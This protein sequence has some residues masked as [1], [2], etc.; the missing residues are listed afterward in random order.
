MPAFLKQFKPTEKQRRF[1]I[2]FGVSLLLLLVMLGHVGGLYKLTWVDKVDA[3]LQDLW[4]GLFAVREVDDRIV[5]VDIDEKSLKEIGRWPW[6]RQQTAQLTNKLFQEYGVAAVGYDVVFAEPD[7]SS[8]LPV[9]EGL[10]AGALAGEA[11]FAE[12]LARLRPS[13][14]YDARLAEALAGGPSVLGFYFNFAANPEIVGQLPAPSIP[15]AALKAAGVTPMR[16]TGYNANLPRLQEKASAAA[17]FNSWPDFDGVNRRMP[18]LMEHDGQ[19][20]GS[21]ALV[22]TQAAMGAAAPKV[23]PAR[24]LRPPA[25][26]LDGLIIPLAADATAVVPYRSMG[27]FQYIS[28]ADVIQDRAPAANLEGRIVLIGSTAPGIMDLRVTPISKVF[29]GV[30]IHANMISGILDGKVKWT[31][32]GMHQIGFLAVLALGIAMALVLPFLSPLWAAATALVVMGVL[33]NLAWYAW[34]AWHAALPVAAPLLTAL[35][36]FVLNMSYGFFVEARSKAQITRLFGQYI[37]PELVDEMAKDPARYSLRGESRVMTVLFSDIVGFTSISEKLEAAQL[38]EMLN[39]YLSHMTHLIQ[40]QRGTIDKYIGDAIMAFWGAPMSDEQHARDGVLTAMAMQAAL[41]DLN[42]KLQEHGWPAVRIGVGVNTGRMSVGN[43]GSEFRMAYTV[44]ADAVNLASRLE[45]LTRQ[46][47]IWVLVG[48]ETRAACPDLSFMQVDRV[49]VKGKAQP[50]AIY[51]PLG[52]TSELPADRI[53]EAEAFEAALEDY[54]HQR[55][56]QA[57]AALQALKQGS[58]RKLCEIYLERIDHFRLNPPPGDWDGVF[59]FTSK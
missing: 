23:L 40:Q 48:E 22:T 3:A 53:R 51:E 16:A 24:G 25:L 35:G 2:Q 7:Q 43:M 30:E 55:W 21:L 41:A 4:T 59:T 26:D 19:C 11:T 33:L 49:R 44:M 54:R 58:R 13:L 15:C 38:A 18:L 28:A 50:V 37:P 29:P 1:L 31:P 42:P 14:D 20:F 52:V 17:F 12:T 32:A 36:L 10:A 46:Y 57:E 5:I 9:L 39:A 45:G 56:S 34:M 6:P 8:G 47:D 27:A